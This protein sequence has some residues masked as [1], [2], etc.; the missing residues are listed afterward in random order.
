MSDCQGLELTPSTPFTCREWRGHPHTW[1]YKKEKEK[2]GSTE[3]GRGRGILRSTNQLDTS[4]ALPGPLPPPA[5]LIPPPEPRWVP[6][7]RPR[8]AQPRAGSNRTQYLASFPDPHPPS[9]L[10]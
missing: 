3:E 9:S 2:N 4:Q 8:P 10:N 7:P 1:G 5:Q 6:E